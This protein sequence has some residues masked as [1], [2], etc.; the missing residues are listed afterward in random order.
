MIV[1]AD[2]SPICYLILINEVE[3]LAVLFRT[4]AIPRAVGQELH[5]PG[6]PAAVAEWVR[7]PP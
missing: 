3:L 1:V 5:H 2:T 4:L 7:S 6:V